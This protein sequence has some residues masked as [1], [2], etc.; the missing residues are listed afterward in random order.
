M[1]DLTVNFDPEGHVYRVGG[2]V[3][4]N[5]TRIIAP[6]YDWTHVPPDVLERKSV[7]G[8]YVHEATEYDDKGRLDEATIAD[9]IRPYLEAWRRFRRETG[10]IPRLIEHKVYH[11]NL[12]YA[13]TL[14]RAGIFPTAADAVDIIDIKS[15][16]E[17]D[18]HGV[19]VAAYAFAYVAERASATYPGR[20]AVY[21]N[22]DGTYRQRKFTDPQDY[23]TFVALLTLA[24]WRQ[25]HE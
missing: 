21:L 10:F 13:G 2:V 6:L 7:L 24:N 4:P 5:V 14:D 16:D 25:N 11:P 9:E 12:G 22:A 17:Y 20:R 1:T 8:R 18:S 15:G 3:V 19:Q 23:P